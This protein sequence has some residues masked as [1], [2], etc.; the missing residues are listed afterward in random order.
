MHPDV[1][2]NYMSPFCH[3]LIVMVIAKAFANRN[4]YKMKGWLLFFNFSV[5]YI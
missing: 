3:S 1:N 2:D 5:Y 4:D